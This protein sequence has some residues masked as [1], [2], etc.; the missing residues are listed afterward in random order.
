MLDDIYAV[1][2]VI[3]PAKVALFYVCYITYVSV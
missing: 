3:C 1:L 2:N